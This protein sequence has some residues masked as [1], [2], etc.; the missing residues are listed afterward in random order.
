[1]NFFWEFD[2]YKYDIGERPIEDLMEKY[3]KL[4]KKSFFFNFKI[5]NST[6]KMVSIMKK[7]FPRLTEIPINIE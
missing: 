2:Y 1:L 6:D 3:K 4:K 5:N 7:N